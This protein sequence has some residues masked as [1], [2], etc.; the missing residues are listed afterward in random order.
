MK[1]I[2]IFTAFFILLSALSL[3][4]CTTEVEPI[5]PAVLDPILTGCTKPTSFHVSDF[6]NGNTINLNWVEGGQ[7][8]SWEIEYGSPGFTLGSGT[9]VIATDNS[10]S[11]DGLDNAI[12]YEF[13][14][15]GVCSEDL[16]STWVGPV[17]I[18]STSV[19]CIAPTGVTA[20]RN[21]TDPTQI[22]LAWTAGGSETAW[23]IQYGTAGFTLGSGTVVDASSPFLVISGLNATQA[24]DFYILSAC[25]AT[26]SSNWVGPKNVPVG[27][28]NPSS[29]TF[30]VDIDG[31]PFTANAII[32]V[33]SVS[34]DPITNEPMVNPD[35]GLPIVEY[36]IAGKYNETKIVTV[37]WTS[38]GSTNSF[39]TPDGGGSIIYMPNAT[40]P[41]NAYTTFDP[42]AID[43][44]GNITITANDTTAKIISGTFHAT[45]FLLDF[46][47]GQV[48]DPKQ[49]TNGIFTNIHYT[50]Q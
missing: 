23:K 44:L 22:A 10:L 24:Y 41:L 11:I 43:P 27:T 35:T 17:S 50:E 38:D 2:K 34:L 47:T 49:F 48:S 16:Q 3:S 25:S 42:D 31:T 39:D 20:A 8:S 28:T 14:I 36:S 30:T 45:V 19:D 15:R 7:E 5:D 40:N 21:P 13:Y 33:K 18:N 9:T 32:A 26:D 4:S 29:G 6:V 37:Q 1:N 46:N 12:Q